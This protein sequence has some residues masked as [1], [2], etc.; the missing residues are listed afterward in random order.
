MR[1]GFG[2]RDPGLGSAGF[3]GLELRAGFPRSLCSGGLRRPGGVGLRC[4]S[5]RLRRER[6]MQ[7]NYAFKPTAG[8]GL[9]PNRLHRPAAA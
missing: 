5:A 2:G 1:L 8:D 9:W 4:W 7:S 3:G 6:G